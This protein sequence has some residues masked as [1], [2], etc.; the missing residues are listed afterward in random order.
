MAC[1]QHVPS[2]VLVTGARGFVGSHLCKLLVQ[3]GWRVTASSRTQRDSPLTPGATE[4]HLSMSSSTKEWQSALT[5]IECIVHL[6]AE[7]HVIGS[8]ER[9]CSPFYEVN[10][11]GSRLVAEQAAR[12]GV[13]RFIFLSTVKVNGEGGSL[14]PY[15]ADDIP[16]PSDPYAQSKLEAERQLRHFCRGAGVE[17]VII[18]PPLVYGPGVRANF[19]RLLRVIE[20]GVPLPLHSIKN[21]RSLISIWN[22][23]DFIET[24]MTHPQAA[25]D[26]W[27][28]SDG[29]DLSTPDLFRKLSG[30]MHRPDRLFAFSPQLLQRIAGAFGMS[31]E[32]N[33]LSTSLVVDSTPAREKLH[34]SPIT[35]VDEALAR[36]VDAYRAACRQ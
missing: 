5:S 27:L 16:A 9:S 29:E 1:A 4:V 20:L 13:R 30:L 21:R 11:L 2:S 8:A 32:F 28:I 31:A 6:A 22:L 24:C 26:T 15:R 35:S 36:T 23:T 14:R 12:A 3:N 34:W 10:V 7:V 17:L 33:R 25:G 18:R 19:Q